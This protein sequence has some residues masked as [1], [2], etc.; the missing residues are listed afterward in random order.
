[1]R[2]YQLLARFLLVKKNNK[3]YIGYLYN[4]HI[5]RQ[6]HIMLPKT[7]AY[8]KSYDGRTKWMSF[9]I[10]DYD[11]LEEYSIIWDKVGADIKKKLIASLSTIK[12][13]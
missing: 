4:N 1:M 10:E 2:K 11:L 8:V 9:L 3:Y 7:S 12:N 6:L 13:F 5:V